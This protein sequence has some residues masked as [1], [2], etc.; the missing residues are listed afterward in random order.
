MAKRPSPSFGGGMN[1]NLVKQMQRMQEDMQKKQEEVEA[2]QFSATAGG[3]AITATVT[4]QR[5]LVS[6][7]LQPEVVDPDDVEMLQDLIVAAVN[8]ALKKAEEKM[9]G[10]MQRFTGG[11]NLPF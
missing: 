3:G 7:A 5:Q 2:E 9:A 8:E 10:E 11:M 1:A 6:V 4:G